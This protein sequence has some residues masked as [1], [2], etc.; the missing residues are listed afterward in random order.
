MSG[1]PRRRRD[2]ARLDEVG[3][4]VFEEALSKRGATLNALAERYGVS[5]FNARMWRRFRRTTLFLLDLDPDHIIDEIAAGNTIAGIARTHDISHALLA[6]WVDTH[7][8]REAVAQARDLAAEAQFDAVKAELDEATNDT[9]VRVAMGKHQ[10]DRFVA[11]RTTRRFTDEK[12]L[13]VTGTEGVEF[14]ISY[15]QK[16]PDAKPEEEAA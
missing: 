5:E 8:D 6:K 7:V 11:E 10:V 1:I 15:R 3:I 16:P 9:S 4:D 2:Y 13:R 14:H 12:Q